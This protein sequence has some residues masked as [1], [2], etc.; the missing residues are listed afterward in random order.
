MITKEELQALLKEQKFSDITAREADVKAM[1]DDEAT[2]VL[3]LSYFNLKQFREAADV[4]LQLAEKNGTS[5][6]WFTVISS[7][8]GDRNFELADKAFHKTL[9]LQAYEKKGLQIPPQMVTYLYM[10]GLT[11]A[12][13]YTAA[14]PLLDKMKNY[15][16]S[17][18]ATADNFVASRGLPVMPAL[19]DYAKRIFRHLENAEARQKWIA[20]FSKGVDTDGKERLEALENEFVTSA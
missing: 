20:E 10:C 14:F 1:E 2:H 19:L 15:Y 5:Q 3:G 4:F 16:I 13:N 9:T 18:F 11:E 12:E 8:V 7:A 6:A 17:I